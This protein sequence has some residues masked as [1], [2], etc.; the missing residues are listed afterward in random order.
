MADIAALVEQL[1]KLTVLETADF[2]EATRVRVGCIGGGAVAVAA[3]GA[4][5]AAGEQR[6]PAPKPKTAF[7]V[8]LTSVPPTKRSPVIKAVR[9]VKAGWVWAEAKA[10]VEGAPS[11]PSKEL[12]RQTRTCQKK[13]EEAGAKVEIK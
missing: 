5:G 7:D 11:G 12:T 10:H 1:G 9:E 13:L 8:I 6:L 3:P 2:G 4:A